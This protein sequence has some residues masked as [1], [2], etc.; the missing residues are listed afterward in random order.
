MGFA[1]CLL[2]LICIGILRQVDVLQKLVAEIYHAELV[3]ALELAV[4]NV[5]AVDDI[6][7]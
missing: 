7:A 6:A 1:Y 4:L 3:D 5:F 2:Y